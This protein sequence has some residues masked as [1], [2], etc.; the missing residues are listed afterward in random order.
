LMGDIQLASTWWLP[1]CVTGITVR[2]LRK[3][4]P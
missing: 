2:Q 1:V 3:A 4:R